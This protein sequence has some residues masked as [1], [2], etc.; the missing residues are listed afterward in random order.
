MPVSASAVNRSV[1]AMQASSPPQKVV[2]R[3]G[4]YCAH[5]SDWLDSFDHRM[6]K[7]RLPVRLTYESAKQYKNQEEQNENEIYA[8]DELPE[9]GL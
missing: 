4:A 8:D 3:V 1:R 9:D 2:L 7:K 5:E 6:S